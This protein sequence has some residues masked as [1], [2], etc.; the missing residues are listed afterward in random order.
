MVWAQYRTCQ[1]QAHWSSTWWQLAEEDDWARHCTV[2]V[3]TIVMVAACVERLDAGESGVGAFGAEVSG[4]E[5]SGV[6]PSVAEGFG[7]S[8]LAVYFSLA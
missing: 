3:Q 2:R 7:K 1:T 5:V 4:A 6:G 8:R